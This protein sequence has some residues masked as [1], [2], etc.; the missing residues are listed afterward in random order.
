MMTERLPRILVAEDNPN[1]IELTIAAFEE[2]GLIDQI[3]IVHNGIEAL[4]Y[5]FCRGKYNNRENISPA[6]VLLDIQMPG[7]D[8]IE[9]LKNIRKSIDHK[10]LPV[11]MLTSSNMES[12]VL[13]CYLEGANGY[14]VKPINFDEFVNKIKGIGIFWATINT[15]P[16]RI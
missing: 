9:V 10:S 13:T 3:D 4:D 16:C 12:D 15:S 6:F 2:C 14:V 7:L 11:V 5:L 8:G 1:D